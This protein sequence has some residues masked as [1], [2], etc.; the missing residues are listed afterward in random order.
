[1]A[2]GYISYINNKGNYGFIESPELQLEDVFFHFTYCEKTYK[3]IYL[4]DKV[5]FDLVK[6]IDN[7]NEAKNVSFIQNA[8]LDCLKLDYKNNRTLQGFLKKNENT[9]Y[10]KDS[11]TYIYIRIS[12]DDFEI[13]IN[14]VYENNINKLIDYKIITFTDKNKIKAININRQLSSDYKYINEGDK[15]VGFVVAII[16]GGYLIKIYD[17]IIGFL[18]NS[19]VLISKPVLEI[20]EQINVTCIKSSNN[21][22]HAVFNLTEN[23]NKENNLK[24]EQNI[25]IKSLKLGDKFHG[26]INEVKGYGIFVL[27][28]N[29]V[30]LLHISKILG[31]NCNLPRTSKKEFLKI[32]KKIFLKEEVIDISIEEI[33]EYGISLNWD[34]TMER[35]KKLH[36]EIY[37]KYINLMSE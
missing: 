1:M 15:I 37:S 27:F 4:S 7:R 22:K 3:H 16:K 13:N 9:Y 21:I 17:S 29:I 2:I 8:S 24:N 12:I 19:L 33:T 28:G 20:D 34:I 5:S 31:E 6:E 26:K 23:I 35:N 18:P 36:Q 10:V 11:V 14:E 30:G 25:F 32:I